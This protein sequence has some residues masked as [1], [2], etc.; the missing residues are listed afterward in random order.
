MVIRLLQNAFVSENSELIMP[1]AKLSSR[2]LWP[3]PR[4]SENI[5]FLHAALLENTF[6]QWKREKGNKILTEL[7]KWSKLNLL[8][9]WSQVLINPII[10]ARSTF[11]VF[12][13]STTFRYRF[14][15]AFWFPLPALALSFLIVRG[16]LVH[17]LQYSLITSYFF[18]FLFL[19]F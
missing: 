12:L 9:Y 3:P 13:N 14:W 4:Q 2:F 17:L 19:N 16:A 8:R 11:M 15:S 18:T 6:S 5:H 7:K 10:F 1:Q